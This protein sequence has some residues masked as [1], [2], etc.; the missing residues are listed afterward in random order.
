MKEFSLMNSRHVRT[1]EEKGEIKYEILFDDADL[2]DYEDKFT[3][4]D[5][6]FKMLK[7]Q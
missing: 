6:N 7:Y 3:S 1:T 5:V 4:R 2:N